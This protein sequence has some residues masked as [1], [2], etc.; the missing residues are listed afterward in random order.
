[1]N[2]QIRHLSEKYGAR[3]LLMETPLMPVASHELRAS[4]Q[5]GKSVSEYVPEA[6][7]SYI[8]EHDLY[9]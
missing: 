4:L 2:E 7:C 5:T 6:V 8:E 1:M 3:I 9:R